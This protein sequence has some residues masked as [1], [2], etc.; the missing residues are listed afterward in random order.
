[1]LLPEQEWY[2]IS[3]NECS[4]VHR[5]YLRTKSSLWSFYYRWN[6]LLHC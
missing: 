3:P 5:N 4:E 1:M 2:N 6:P